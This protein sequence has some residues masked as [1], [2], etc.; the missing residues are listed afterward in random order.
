MKFWITT[1]VGALL[2]T[3]IGTIAFIR[4]PDMQKAPKIEVKQVAKV[5]DA[6]APIAEVPKKEIKIADVPQMKSD[7]SHFEIKN[8]GKSPLILR[9]G[10][11]SCQCIK[12]ELDVEE[13]PPGGKAKLTMGWETKTG[14][15]AKSLQS[16]V[17]T[18]DPNQLALVFT[19]VLDI[20]QDMLLDPPELNFGRLREG[21]VVERSAF[22][23]TPNF[24]DFK[25]SDL[26]P[27]TKA[28]VATSRPMTPEEL[29]SGK[30]RG[31]SGVRISIVCD[32]RLPVGEFAENVTFKTNFDR[33]PKFT[34]MVA[35]QVEGNIVL[36]PAKLDFGAIG[37]PEKAE[38]QK[39]II[40]ASGLGKQESLRIGAIEPNYVAAS[41]ERN[42]DFPTNWTM[43]VR[44]TKDT[45]A[46]EF[47]CW[48]S[49][50]DSKGVKRIS[51]P[52]V[53]V[54]PGILDLPGPA[55]SPGNVGN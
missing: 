31:K 26:Q 37:E 10:K 3:A 38:P 9:L 2:L 1:V 32:G 42:K 11:K 30:R 14:V 50:V 21:E 27:S 52:V 34:M 17:E 53:G 13:V 35:G 49:L 12:H 6:N 20:V 36:S 51:V 16:V 47:K 24:A 8:V 7:V 25:I 23:F 15:G 54:M 46:G 41:L 55:T 48:I 18:N 33:V 39:Q 19:V 40:F 29:K 43:L 45:P 4:N 44:L 22:M 28:F 5:V